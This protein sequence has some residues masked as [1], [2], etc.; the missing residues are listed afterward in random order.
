MMPRE[1]ADA[2]LHAQGVVLFFIFVVIIVGFA[3]VMSN[4]PP[5]SGAFAAVGAVSL[6]LLFNVY[7][8]IRRLAK[9]LEME[10]LA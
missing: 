2:A 3:S 8:R 7:H 9:L 1:R 4:P 6:I 5:V 10:A